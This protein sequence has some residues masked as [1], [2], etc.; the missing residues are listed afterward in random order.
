MLEPPK[1]FEVKSG[2]AR[3]T[4]K[5]RQS[6]S[7]NVQTMS[8]LLYILVI[9]YF[10]FELVWNN[11]FCFTC[12]GSCVSMYIFYEWFIYNINIFRD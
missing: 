3:T 12:T 1:I 5:E 9:W 10:D 4:L 11:F 2:V 8:N 7:E 6:V